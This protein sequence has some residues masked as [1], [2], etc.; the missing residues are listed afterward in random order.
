MSFEFTIVYYSLSMVSFINNTQD[1]T[2][3]VDAF[4]KTLFLAKKM[5]GLEN[6][7]FKKYVTCNKC[8]KL[9]SFKDAFTIDENGRKQSKL[10]N[11]IEYP[12]HINQ[13]VVYS[14]SEASTK[15]MRYIDTSCMS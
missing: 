8:S 14:L 15:N 4:P 12:N 9:Y 5:I 7:N 2:E 10:C 13:P 6:D 1:M 3:V 11:H